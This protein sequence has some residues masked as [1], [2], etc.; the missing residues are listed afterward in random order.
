VFISDGVAAM[1][2]RS[3]LLSIGYETSLSQVLDIFATKSYQPISSPKIYFMNIDSIKELV[4]PLKF[5]RDECETCFGIYTI[6]RED[7]S[8][9]VSFEPQAPKTTP[10]E[11]KWFTKNQKEQLMEAVLKHHFGYL[12]KQFTEQGKYLIQSY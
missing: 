7:N 5:T 12:M 8:I 10:W 4:K 2:H 6:E 3:L 11:S 1:W 9:R